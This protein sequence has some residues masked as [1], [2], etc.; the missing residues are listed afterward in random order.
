M[1]PDSP[2]VPAPERRLRLLPVLIALLTFVAFIPSLRGEFLNWDDDA[3]YLANVHYRGL[4]WENLQWMFSNN[5]GHFMPLTWI[6]LGMDYLLWGMNPTGYHATSMALH[7]VNAALLYFLIRRL[8]R[9]SRPEASAGATAVSAALGA[10]FFSIH[11]LRVE[12]VAWITE[13]RD[14]LSCTFFLGTLLTYLRSAEAPAAARARWTW[15]GGSILCF[16]GMLLSKTMGLTLPFVMLVLDVYPLRRTS[17]HSK[18]ALVAE[19]LPYLALMVGAMVMISF[20]VGKAEAFY[21]RDEYPLIQS[22]AQPGYRLSFYIGKTFLP[23][24]LSPL[25]AYR[26]ELGWPQILG[27]LA[28]LGA[29][30][31]LVA[32]RSRRPAPLA[33]YL[34]FGLLA[35]PISGLVQ[36]G[37]QSTADRYTYI[38]CLPFAALVAGAG[39]ALEDRRWRRP[40]LAA[41]GALLLGLGALT[42]RQCGFWTDSVRLWTRAIDLEPDVYFSRDRRAQAF[43][44]RQEWDRALA[45][46]DV[47]V[48]LNGNWFE[49]RGHRAR[50][51]LQTGD[52]AGAIEDASRAIALSPDFAEAYVT[53]ARALSRLGKVREAIADFSEALRLRPGTVEA[54]VLRALEE[55]KAGQIDAARADLDAAVAQDP[56]AHIYLRRAN[57]RALQKDLEGAIADC[58]EAIRLQPRFADAYLSRGVARL[59]RGQSAAAAEDFTR[60]LETAP[61]A[62]PPRK[63][64]EEFLRQARSGSIK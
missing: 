50:A 11:P 15:L 10:L 7:A 39:L 42:W 33:A 51:R 32:G 26:A 12:S 43:A 59:E 9:R 27:W 13:R 20:S 45:D 18:S 63:Q 62:W 1:E 40:A 46:L 29:L 23:F 6:T 16:A 4:G 53:R 22:I 54:R 25:Y 49:S 3:S 64:A 60:A 55:M 31:F 35:A 8:L 47:S 5:Y 17:T 34:C 58:T 37:P 61:P 21:S 57:L 28:L 48:R 56:Q 36:V 30:A 2:A 19:K 52:P 38:P 24:N 44:A 41:A 14:V